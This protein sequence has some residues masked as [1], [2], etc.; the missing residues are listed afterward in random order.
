M[1]TAVKVPRAQ[2]REPKSVNARAFAA[3]SGVTAALV[4]AAIVVFA[5][6]AVYVGFE[7][8]PFGSGDSADSTV[9]LQS[10]APQ[11][12]AL[13]AGVTADAVAADPADPTPAARAEILAA[14][15]PGATDGPGPGG[16]TDDPPI[17]GGGSGPGPV[18]PVD[19]VD[20]GTPGPIQGTIGGVDD[21]A[22]GLGPDLPLSE[23]TDPVTQPV[24]DV[25]GGTLNNVGNG[26]GAGNL[27][28]NVNGTLN[29]V[30]GGLLGGN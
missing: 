20:P 3:G 6:V 2:T 25:V 21:A 5:S 15:P 1:D 28:D 16:P 22:G 7:G 19:P 12:A 4:A 23:L 8:M 10:G 29:G 9:S 18:D 14:L 24:D 13:A 17:T 30:T 27:G 11:A 26:V